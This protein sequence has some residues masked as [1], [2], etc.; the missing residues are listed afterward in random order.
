M[1]SRNTDLVV[2]GILALLLAGAGIAL[3]F[4]GLPESRVPLTPAELAAARKERMDKLRALDGDTSHPF[5]LAEA[6]NIER[7]T[8]RL[9]WTGPEIHGPSWDGKTKIDDAATLRFP[10]GAH[11]WNTR[12]LQHVKPFP[13]DLLVLGAGM[14]H[15]LVRIQE[16]ATNDDVHSL[17]FRNL[18]IDC[19]NDYFTDLRRGPVTI[20]LD[21]CRIVRFDCGHGGSVLLAARIAALHA[22]DCVFETGYGQHPHRA[23]LSRV[24]RFLIARFERC[25]FR[26]LFSYSLFDDR[27]TSTEVF[28]DCV[29]EGIAD[30]HRAQFASPP[31]GVRLEGCTV[32]FAP[33]GV[34]PVTRPLADINP[35]WYVPTR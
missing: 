16:I 12:A 32:T 3:T 4:W 5:V 8:K 9:D 13:R 6:G 33:R 15:T 27:N 23:A 26:G 10:A 21:R 30:K 24:G 17:T 7:F 34:R 35:A 19:G 18:T 29:F 20:R 22:T 11:V 14:D 2:W 28:A 31:P 1:R 25:T